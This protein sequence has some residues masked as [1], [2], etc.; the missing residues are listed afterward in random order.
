[1]R[2]FA[3]PQVVKWK[4]A[5]GHESTGLLY[6]PPQRF[7]GKRPVIVDH[8]A[9][10]GSQWRAGFLG[11]ANYV[12]GELG[13]AILR[14]NVR[15]SSGFG[16]SQAALGAGS[17]RGD[18]ARD[19]TGLLEWIGRQPALDE[20]RTL[21]V[22]AGIAGEPDDEAFIAAAVDFARRVQR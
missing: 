12:L 3:E 22:G 11:R 9:G 17:L 20:S 14:P 10:P 1:M 15:G 7:S 2:G 19:I 16:K 21:V 8:R 6:M 13:V 5:D 18:A 4:A